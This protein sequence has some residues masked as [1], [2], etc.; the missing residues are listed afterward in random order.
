MKIAVVVSHPIQHFCPMYASWSKN[1]NVKLKVFFASNIGSVPY[2][3]SDFGKQVK[4][5]NLYLE[6]FDHCFLNGQETFELN[7]KLDAPKLGVELDAFQPDLVIQYGYSYEFIKRLRIWLK[8]KQVK[9]AYISDTENRHYEANYRRW[10][11]RLI[12]SKYFKKMDLFLSVG[13]A[14]EDYYLKN[15]VNGKKIIRMNFS[16]DVNHFDFFYKQIDANRSEFR[17]LNNVDD[18]DIVISVVGKLVEWK[19]QIHLIQALH[20]LETMNPDKR[21]HLLIAGSGPCEF[22]LR[23]ESLKLKYN[24]VHF[25]DFVN[26]MQLPVIYAASDL[27]IHPSSFEP[28]SLAVS[29]AIYMGLPVILSSTSG[30][31]GPTDDVRIGINGEIYVFGDIQNLVDSIVKL[32]NSEKLR[33]EYRQN[34]INISRSQQA[35]CH[36]DILKNIVAHP[37][38][39]IRRKPQF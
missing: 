19:N 38:F 14:N 12:I 2:H 3:D 25:L 22:K 4:W 28:H 30:S 16:I 24:K 17:N 10:I 13:D 33:K 29:E 23:E 26:P 9:S 18:S 27:Y 11:K 20:L 8:G 35:I 32:S 15:G 36:S 21:Y 37:I 5:D 1:E 6:E 7:K 34:S 39:Q 31:Y